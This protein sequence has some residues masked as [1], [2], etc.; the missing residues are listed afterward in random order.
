MEPPVLS[1]QHLGK[2]FGPVVAL[3]G[4]DFSLQAGQIHAI[5]GENGAGKSTLIKTLCGVHPKSSYEGEVRIDGQV[6]AFSSV[7]DAEA[8]GVG[9]IHQELALVNELTV[10]EN[11]ALGNE[12]VRGAFVDWL[13][14]ARRAQELIVRLGVDLDPETRVGSLGVGHKQLVEILRALGKGK[15]DPHPGR[16]DGCAQ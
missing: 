10:A 13:A 5:C 12:P 1:T 14:M 6:V 8:K 2:R 7:R 11:I 4:V 16:T 15:S 9:V 3:S